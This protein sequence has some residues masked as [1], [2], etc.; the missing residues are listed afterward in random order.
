MT[1]TEDFGGL[2]AGEVLRF[3]VA[4]NEDSRAYLPV[5][6]R[7]GRVVAVDAHGRP[8]L[9]VR[10]TGAGRTVLA[11]YPLEHMAARTPHVNPDATHRLYA[12]LAR[13][14]GVRRPV[15]V[16]DPHVSADVLVHADGR[17][18]VWLVSQSPEPLVVHPDAEGTLHALDGGTPVEDVPLEAYGVAVL[19][20]RPERGPV[21]E[22]ERGPVQGPEREREPEPEPESR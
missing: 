16:P 17:C 3:P 6:P 2:R 8:A 10:E 14:A 13:V 22:P 5:E 11:T 4:G 1:F 15:T 21:Q 7:E 19:E 18:F 9:L 12:A 20:L